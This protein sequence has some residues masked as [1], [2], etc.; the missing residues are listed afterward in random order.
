MTKNPAWTN[1]ELILALDF[2]FKQGEE[3]ILTGHTATP[4]MARLSEELNLLATL[5]NLPKGEKFRSPKAVKARINNFNDLNPNYPTGG[6]ANSGKEAVKVW[7]KFSHQRELLAQTATAIRQHLKHAEA[8]NTPLLIEA[9]EEILFKPAIEGR[10]LS[11]SHIRRERNPSL[12]KKLKKAYYKEHNYLD[13]AVCGFDYEK[14]YGEHG[15]CFMEAHHKRP[16]CELSPEGEK[17]K[18]SDLA[19]ICASC[20]RMVHH[21]SP[22]LTLD[23]LREILRP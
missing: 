20:H 21:K 15:H 5:H 7:E 1:D 9:T 4:E 14:R 8:T 13:C 11:S 16:L 2:Y 23:Q 3:G 19:L 12:V 6:L 18:A 17:V 10:I 22:W